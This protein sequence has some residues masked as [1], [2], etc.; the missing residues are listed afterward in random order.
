MFVTVSRFGKETY[1]SVEAVRE[2]A[3]RI[4]KHLNEL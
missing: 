2:E 4:Q 3:D 1:D